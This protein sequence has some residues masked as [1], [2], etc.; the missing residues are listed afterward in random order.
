[1]TQTTELPNFIGGPWCGR[2]VTV[3]G[4]L[5]DEIELEGGAGSYHKLAAVPNWLVDIPFRPSYP[6]YLWEPV[7]H[8]LGAA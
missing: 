7:Y 8:D 2:P 6:V 5:H 1:M 4:A 3:T